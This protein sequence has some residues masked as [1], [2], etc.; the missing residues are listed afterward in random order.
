MKK[1]NLFITLGLA[2]GL[3]IGATVG[4]VANNEVK[5]ANATGT[6]ITYNLTGTHNGWITS[7]NEYEIVDGGSAVP[8]TFAAEQQFKFVHDDAWD[9]S[10]GKNDLQGI[11]TARSW[12]GDYGDNIL[13]I[14]GGTYNVTILDG[15]VYIDLQNSVDVYVQ[16]SGW[17]HTYVYAFDQTTNATK[18]EPFGAWPG[19]EV[20]N[21]TVASNFD[22][23]LGG[24][25]KVS[26]P[27]KTLS[28]TKIIV[29]NNDGGQS[30][31]QDVYAGYYY[32][33]DGAMGDDT[34]GEQ[35]KVVFDIEKAIDAAN[36]ASV[37]E[38]SKSVATALVAEFDGLTSSGRVTNSTMYT[39][40]TTVGDS[41]A[42]HSYADI[43]AELRAIAESGSGS[44]RVAFDLLNGNSNNSFALI[45]VAVSATALVAVGGYF[46]L[47]KRKED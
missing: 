24:I 37:C 12:F 5:E 3:G 34:Y 33:K 43:I 23:G 10:L 16:V 27:Y 40:E 46:L 38:I 26:V 31:N 20:S 8:V 18:L 21:F 30:Q 36:N 35:A 6:G 1:R 42:N 7:D 4:L 22:N 39:W 17:E 15:K 9:G 47:R 19:R 25:A 28:N 41:K 11:C 32:W 29:N 45:I 44:G 13:C 2:L 14:V